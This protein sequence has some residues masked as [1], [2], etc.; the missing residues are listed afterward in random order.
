M[1]QDDLAA[2]VVAEAENEAFRQL[3]TSKE[4]QAVVAEELLKQLDMFEELIKSDEE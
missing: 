1:E 4:F 2:R 3:T